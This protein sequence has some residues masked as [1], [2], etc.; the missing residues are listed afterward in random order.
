MLNSCLTVREKEPNSHAN[1]GWEQFTDCVLSIVDKY[2]GA[3]LPGSSGA[4][5]GFGRGVVFMAWG[6]YA[7]KRV[8][9][10]DKV[11]CTLNPD[12]LALIISNFIV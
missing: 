8:A 10:L 1:K 3:N 5:S 12:F 2:G 11:S 9:K 7:A 4:P 6:A